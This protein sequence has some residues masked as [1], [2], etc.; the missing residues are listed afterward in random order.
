MKKSRARPGGLRVAVL[1]AIAVLIG[2]CGYEDH[3]PRVNFATGEIESRPPGRFVVEYFD[4]DIG[5]SLMS[6]TSFAQ[7]RAMIVRDNA[8]G[9]RYLYVG[10]GYGGGLAVMPSHTE[11]GP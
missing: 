10:N 4:W 9:D 5:D 3:S 11:K 7:V 2:G 1:L 8:T 6:D